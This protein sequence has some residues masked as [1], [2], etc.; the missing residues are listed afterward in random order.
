MQWYYALDGQ[1]IGPVPHPELERLIQN[2]T[3]NGET[4]V[5]RQ[6]MDQWKPLGDVQARDPALF[7]QPAPPAMPPLPD[8]TDAVR[9]DAQPEAARRDWNA[10][11]TGAD[12]AA[13]ATEAGLD[14]AGFWQ[15]AGAFVLDAIL[16]VMGLE[17][18]MRLTVARWFPDVVELNEKI[19]ATGKPWAYQ[20]TPEE[21]ILTLK[22]TAFMLLIGAVWGLAY[23]LFF[24]L[25]FSATPG[26]LLF[27]MRV[28]GTTGEPLGFVRIVARHLA[29]WLGVFTLGIGYLIVAFDEEKRALHDFFCGTRVIKK[30]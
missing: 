1:R 17:I 10:R 20:P 22:Y 24:M 6:G 18:L 2:R 9:P 8:T 15:R 13:A 5:W 27:G 29:R 11:P 16:Y 21:M 7:A 30:R 19:L 14:Y 23:D 25:K 12:S 28:V 3:L 26:K 4:L